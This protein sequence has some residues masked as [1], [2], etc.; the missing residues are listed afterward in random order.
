MGGPPPWSSHLPVSPY[1]ATPNNVP[2][3]E[4]P[5]LN[6]KVEAAP[7]ISGRSGLNPY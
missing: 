4:V 7:D 1:T 5:R 3:V 6:G 2:Q